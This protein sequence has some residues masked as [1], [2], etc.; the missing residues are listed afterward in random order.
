MSHDFIIALAALATSVISLVAS[1]H[2]SR[3][4]QE[5]NRKSVLPLPYVECSDYV[6]RLEVRIWNHGTGP[7]LVRSL[8]AADARQSDAQIMRIIPKPPACYR[9]ADY[10]NFEEPRPIPPGAHA[11]I[12][13]AEL[14]P[15]REEHRTYHATLR[16]FLAQTTIRCVYTDVYGTPFADHIIRLAWFGRN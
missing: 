3:L 11:V 14:D 15:Q 1:I 8:T 6:N 12:I 10:G 13:A 9:F 7:M 5:H 4:A 2:F 16:A